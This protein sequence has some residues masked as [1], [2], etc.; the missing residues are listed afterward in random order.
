MNCSQSYSSL[1]AFFKHIPEDWNFR[2]KNE[3]HLDTH[4]STVDSCEK[5]NSLRYLSSFVQ[6]Y[7]LTKRVHMTSFD[8][9]ATFISI[10]VH[11]TAFCMGFSK[12]E[13]AVNGKRETMQKWE[14]QRGLAVK[15]FWQEAIKT[16]CS[17]VSHFVDWTRYKILGSSTEHIKY[18]TEEEILTCWMSNIYEWNWSCIDHKVAQ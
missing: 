13:K 17:S 16:Q 2:S 10:T 4:E 8:L 14:S 6:K 15:N 7:P 3:L 11:Y 18:W 1:C 9:Q 5:S 12:E